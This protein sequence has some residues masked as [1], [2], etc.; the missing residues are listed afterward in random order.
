MTTDVVDRIRALRLRNKD[1]VK[2]LPGN[3][4]EIN[5]ESAEQLV[6]AQFEKLLKGLEEIVPEWFIGAC[7]DWGAPAY[8]PSLVGMEF[9]LVLRKALAPAGEEVEQ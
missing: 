4:A 2:A 1:I 5:W 6:D 9:K 3:P 8:T 7:E